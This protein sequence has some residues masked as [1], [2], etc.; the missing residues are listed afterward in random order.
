MPDCVIKFDDEDYVS[1]RGIPAITANRFDPL[2]IPH[3][4][5][6]D[7]DYRIKSYF[8][9][10]SGLV[11]VKSQAWHIE[12]EKQLLLRKQ[13]ASY[14]DKIKALPAG[15]VV[16]F[17]E[18][19]AALFDKFI[20][21]SVEKCGDDTFL[22][23]PTFLTGPITQPIMDSC[24]YALVMEGMPTSLAQTETLDKPAAENVGVVPEK[25]T[26][27]TKPWLIPD[28]SDP[29]PDQPWYT[30]ARYF[31]RQLIKDDTTLLNKRPILASKVAQSLT[32]AGIKKRGGEHPLDP[33]TVL[34]AFSNVSL[35]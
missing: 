34:K 25:K 10:I 2:Y 19:S 7:D 16:S 28:P 14:I 12:K 17:E 22:D 11:E 13:G 18:L 33:A 27:G 26:E 31:A 32:T 9:E 21:P 24:T 23:D 30:P 1:V 20:R 8:V 4:L 6:G 35:G 29:T 3:L 15:I 5:G